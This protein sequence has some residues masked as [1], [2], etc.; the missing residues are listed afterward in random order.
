LNITVERVQE[1]VELSETAQQL[2]A[3]LRAIVTSA[4]AHARDF[5]YAAYMAPLEDV[6]AEPYRALMADKITLSEADAVSAE[7]RRIHR[8]FIAR[9]IAG[10]SRVNSGELRTRG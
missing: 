9:A 5:D 2:T 4:D 1:R 3:R 7:A 8:D 10:P 6:L